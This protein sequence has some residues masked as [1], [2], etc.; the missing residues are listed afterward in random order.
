M[1]D[2]THRSAITGKFV[3]DEHAEASPDTTV[4][5]SPCTECE[6]L[7]G[8]QEHLHGDWGWCSL[9]AGNRGFCPGGIVKL[10]EHVTMP[11]RWRVERRE[12]REQRQQAVKVADRS[13]PR[14]D[15]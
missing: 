3:T 5:E 10:A 4:S 7:R 9:A 11:A 8:R 1:T 12:G 13:R 6:R 2:K 14:M 15:R